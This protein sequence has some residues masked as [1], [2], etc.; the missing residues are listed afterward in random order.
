MDAHP[1]AFEVV[2]VVCALMLATAAVLVVV[3]MALG[4]TMLDRAISL[5]VLLAV[6]LC[7]V[8]LVTAWVDT[9]YLIPVLLVSTLLGFVGT[10]SVARYARGS[11]DVTDEVGSSGDEDVH[12]VRDTSDDETVRRD[13]SDL[14]LGEER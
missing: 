2:L 10:V 12:V 6:C 9:T 8:A 13:T 5:D 7:G 3:R 14:G 1:L 4:P 11:D